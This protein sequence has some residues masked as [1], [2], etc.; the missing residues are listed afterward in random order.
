MSKS[1]TFLTLKKEGVQM[2]VRD[3]TGMSQGHRV[4]EHLMQRY[5]SVKWREPLRALWYWR[6]WHA[7]HFKNITQM[8]ASGDTFVGAETGVRSDQL[9][10]YHNSSL[11]ASW[12]RKM[13][14]WRLYKRHNIPISITTKGTGFGIWP[15]KGWISVLSYSNCLPW[16]SAS[17][18]LHL[19]ERLS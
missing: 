15:S 14:I 3:V 9:E 1:W 13:G 19:R 7:L 16:H 8:A 4:L 2:D 18:C 11:R 5:L 10:D 17:S 12:A 6:Q